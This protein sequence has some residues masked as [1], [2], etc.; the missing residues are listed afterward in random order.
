[1]H[2]QRALVDWLHVRNGSEMNGFHPGASTTVADST[3][4]KC[5]RILLFIIIIIDW[6]F[7]IYYYYLSLSLLIGCAEWQRN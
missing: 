2:C 3:L 5:R 1:M 4:H 6:L 7:I